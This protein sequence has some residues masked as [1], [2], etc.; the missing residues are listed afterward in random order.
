MEPGYPG[1]GQE[2]AAGT[3]PPVDPRTVY[4]TAPPS[5]PPPQYPGYLVPLI[6]VRPVGFNNTLG[7]LSMIFGI[8][9][10]PLLTC[11]PVGSGFG[12]AAIVLGILG[13]RKAARG[14]ADNRGMSIAG[15]ACGAAGIA[16]TT[17]FMS[18]AV[19]P[20]GIPGLSD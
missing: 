18:L 13:I 17:L 10:L 20:G 4:P 9:S 15:I 11:A 2:P 5:W 16:M 12:I 6:T 14:L 1:S 3:P 7:L 19:L 8:I